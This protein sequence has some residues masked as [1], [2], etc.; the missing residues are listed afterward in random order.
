MLHHRIGNNQTQM[1]LPCLEF[2]ESMEEQ[3]EMERLQELAEELAAKS[4]TIYDE[5]TKTFNM[6]KR[7]VTE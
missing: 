6:N 7:M 5:K 3:K 2:P 4:R 1:G